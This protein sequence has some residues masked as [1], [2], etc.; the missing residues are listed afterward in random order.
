MPSPLKGEGKKEGRR[1]KVASSRRGKKKNRGE[2]GSPSRGR[3]KTQKARPDLINTVKVML[4]L[5]QK[6]GQSL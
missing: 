5:S 2:E 6:T 3:E 1:G 4:K